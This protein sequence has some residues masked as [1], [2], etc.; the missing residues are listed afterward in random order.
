[1]ARSARWRRILLIW[2]GLFLGGYAA[3][4][5]FLSLTQE[6]RIFFP[7]E[8]QP[9]RAGEILGRVAGA[10]SIWL[11]AKDGTRL[12]GW[13]RPAAIGRPSGRLL[14]YFGGNAEDVHWRLGAAED[15]PGWD[16]LLTDYRGYGLSEGEP[17]QVKLQE[18]ALLW[19]DSAAADRIEGLP[20]PERIAV[21]G[22]SL[23]SYYA[24]YLAAQRPVAGIVL[25]TPFDSVRDYVAS[26]LPLVPV[27]LLLRHPMDSIAHAAS[28]SAPSLF[29]VAAADATIPPERARIL[30]DAW[31]GRPR[32]WVLVPQANHDTISADPAYGEALRRFLRG[33]P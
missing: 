33:L 18:D 22:T 16:I 21:M 9:S 1:M 15:Y 6:S 3:A 4:L 11:Q 14:I 19:F 13:W 28:I 7:R 25:A 24:T 23:G 5:A 29:L 31:A 32:D 8:L 2:L 17:A 12:H 20:I 10:R 30:Y 26:R 27:R